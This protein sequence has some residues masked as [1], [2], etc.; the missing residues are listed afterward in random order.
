MQETTEAAPSGD[1]D[2]PNQKRCGETPE[3][4]PASDGIRRA[5]RE[6][7]EELAGIDDSRRGWQWRSPAAAERA[8]MSTLQSKETT[9]R[10]GLPLSLSVSL[11][12]SP[13]DFQI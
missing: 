11:R 8:C 7:A 12:L 3:K 1:E 10:S 6:R 2:L 5:A 9:V 4:R 13:L